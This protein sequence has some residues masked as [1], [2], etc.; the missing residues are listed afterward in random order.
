MYVV[1]WFALS[2]RAVS[3]SVFVSVLDWLALRPSAVS[4]SV[5]VYV[6]SGLALDLT[7]YLQRSCLMPVILDHLPLFSGVYWID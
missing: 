4:T 1:D 6:V 5:L 3:T 7:V 2:P